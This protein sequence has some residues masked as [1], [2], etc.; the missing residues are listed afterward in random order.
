MERTDTKLL[1]VIAKDLEQEIIRH[2]IEEIK[3]DLQI[4]V[5]GLKELYK[6]LEEFRAIKK[7]LSKT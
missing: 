3:Q 6:E 1:L 7:I 4:Q 5:D 2:D